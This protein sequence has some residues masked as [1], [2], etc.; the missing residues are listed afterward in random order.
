MNLVGW[1]WIYG[2]FSSWFLTQICC[3][4]GH[5][6]HVDMIYWHLFYINGQVNP[7]GMSVEG[8]AVKCLQ[9]HWQ[10]ALFLAWALQTPEPFLVTG[11]PC[12]CVAAVYGK[13]HSL[14]SPSPSFGPSSPNELIWLGLVGLVLSWMSWLM[15]WGQAGG[16]GLGTSAAL[17]EMT[18]VQL[19][20][21][22][23]RP[24]LEDSCEFGEVGICTREVGGK[25]EKE[26]V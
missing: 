5:Q 17:L 18:W 16:V 24:H 22:S 10:G 8:I 11:M 26:E 1:L 23:L 12:G 3:I 4:L 7:T 25:R 9:H 6:C 13:H 19:S 14:A 2:K 15:L 21:S 20:S